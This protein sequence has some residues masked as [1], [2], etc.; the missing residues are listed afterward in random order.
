MGAP[1][2][3]LHCH[4]LSP[5]CQIFSFCFFS[6]Y[7][8][9]SMLI[10]HLLIKQTFYIEYL[11]CA[12]PW[13]LCTHSFFHVLDKFMHDRLWDALSSRVRFVGRCAFVGVLEGLGA[14]L[15]SQG[16]N[17]P[18][19]GG[20]VSVVQTML[21]DILS[22]PSELLV[23]AGFS[24]LSW[25]GA[26]IIVQGQPGN[27]WV[28]R[29]A[30]NGGEPGTPVSWYDLLVLLKVISDC[31]Q[32][33]SAGPA[34]PSLPTSGEL[35]SSGCA[36]KQS[37]RHRPGVLPSPDSLLTSA[38]GLPALPMLSALLQA[39]PLEAGLLKTRVGCCRDRW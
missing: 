4:L 10:A 2:S 1:A 24:F 26:C 34:H 21:G 19:D 38:P 15:P 37:H 32:V 11:L 8:N 39:Q 28:G 17:A 13:H 33:C 14:E 9:T 29:L 30:G 36:L 31:S 12:R 5:Y 3:W 20:Y 23:W 35:C 27:G 7:K 18:Q 22:F 25:S 6:Y 16:G